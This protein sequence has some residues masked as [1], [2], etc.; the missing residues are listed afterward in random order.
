VAFHATLASGGQGIFVGNAAG[1]AVA[2]YVDHTGPFSTFAPVTSINSA[3]DVAFTAFLD[4]GASGLF[5]GTNPTADRVI[6][7][8]DP[9]FGSIINEIV[10]SNASL[11]DDGLVAFRYSLTDGRRGIALA[12]PIPATNSADFDMDMDVDGVDFL[13]W[14]RGFGIL[15]TAT[16]SQG[17]ANGDLDVDRDDL[18]VWEQQFGPVV[19]AIVPEPGASMLFIVAALFRR[20]G[21]RMKREL[22]AQSS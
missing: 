17:D 19:A 12:T 8:G 15:G 20:F 6:A 21:G 2:T 22:A 11:N 3:G 9:L 4:G 5:T 13:I 18:S 14:Q 1:G 10:I 16:L 7:N